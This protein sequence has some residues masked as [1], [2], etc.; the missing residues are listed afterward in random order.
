[1]QTGTPKFNGIVVAD[2]T[3]NFLEMSSTLT[4]RAAFV[5]S[6]SGQTHGWTNGTGN[7]WSPETVAILKSLRESMERDLVNVHMVSDGSPGG[8]LGGAAVTTTQP[9]GGLGEF[10]ASQEKDAPAL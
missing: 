1:M 7:I 6:E 4:C 8:N 9:S 3:F 10:L 5:S 2:G